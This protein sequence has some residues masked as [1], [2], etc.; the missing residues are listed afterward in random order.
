MNKEQSKTNLNGITVMSQ[1][2]GTRRTHWAVCALAATAAFAAAPSGQAAMGRTAGAFNVSPTGAATYSIPI[3][4]PKGPNGVQPNLSIAYDSNS[5]DGTMGPGW[6]LSGLGAISRCNKTWAQDGAPSAVALATSDGYCLNGNRLRMTSGTYGQAGSTYQTE[7]ADFSNITAY[8][9]AGNG[10]SHFFVQE[11]NGWTYEYGNSNDGGSTYPARITASGSSTPYQWLV[12]KVR[13]KAG[14]NYVVSYGAGQSG[15]VGIGVPLSLSYTPSAAGSSSYEYTLTFGYTTEGAAGTENGYIGGGNVVNTNRLTSITLAHGAATVRKYN[16]AYGQS[17]TTGRYRL[18]SLTECSDAASTNCLLPTAITYQNGSAGVATSPVTAVSSSCVIDLK[19]RDINNDGFNDLTC[20]SYDEESSTSYFIVSFGSASGFS[21]FVNAGVNAYMQVDFDHFLGDGIQDFL[22]E[23]DGVFYRYRWNGSSF[24]A[25]NTGVPVAPAGLGSPSP[26]VST[27]MNGDGL[28]DLVWR[29]FTGTLYARINTSSG[30]ALSFTDPIQVYTN[31]TVPYTPN[32]GIF[33]RSVGSG[34]KRLDFNGDGRGDIHLRAGDGSAVYT[35]V[36]V[37]NGNSYS[38]Q[39]TLNSNVEITASDMNDDGCTD[40]YSYHRFAE[41]EPALHFSKCNGTQEAVVTATNLTGSAFFPIDWN[42]DGTQDLMVA[43]FT[44]WQVYLVNGDGSWQSPISTGISPGLG[45][46][47]WAIV[48]MNGDGQ[49]DLASI[50]PYSF[51]G[52]IYSHLHNGAS[53]LPDRVTSIVDGYGVAFSPAYASITQG[54]YTQGSGA[55][56]PE[57]DTKA[58]RYVVSQVTTSDGIGGTYNK[59]YTYSGGRQH[60]QGRG[61][62]GFQQQTVTDSRSGAPVT[63]SYFKTT[64]PHTGMLY[65]Q[66]VFQSNG[67]TLISRTVN[68]TGLATLDATANNQRYFPNIASAATDTYEVG[69]TKNAALV[70]QR[71]TSLTYDSYGNVTSAT[72]TLTDKDSTSP[73]SPT[74]NQAWTTT[75]TNSFTPDAGSNWCVGIPTQTTVAR[76]TTGSSITRTTSITPN[77]STCRITQK[78]VEPSSGTYAVTIGYGYDA[79]GNVSSETVTGVGMSARQTLM[80]WGTTGQFPVSVTNALSQTSTAGYN[81]DLGVQMTATDANG[82]ATSFMHD[83]FAR[84]TRETRPD[85]TYTDFTYTDCTSSGCQNGDPSGSPAINKMLVAATTKDSAATTIRDDYTHLDQFD[86]VIV[87][88]SRLLGS[89]YSRVGTQYDALGNVY[90]QTAPC[91]AASCSVYWTTNTYDA[92]NRLTNQSRPISASVGTLQS[93]SYSYQGMTTLVT[94][95]PTGSPASSKTTTKVVDPNGWLRQSRDHNNYYQNFN[96]DAFGS[97]KTVTDSLSNALFSANYVY[98]IGAFQTSRTDMDLGTWSFT[99]NA[100]GEVGAYTDAKGNNFTQTFDAL[101]RVTT[102]FVTGEGTTTW[103]WGNNAANYNIGQLASLSNT[104]G[105]IEEYS[106]D[107]KSRLSQRKITS[108]AIYYFNYTYGS[109]GQID[110]LTYPTSTSSY[111]LSVKHLYENGLLKQVKDDNASTV[112]WQAGTV[113]PRGQVSQETLGNGVVTNRVYD[114]VTGWISSIQS[115]SGGGS[116]LQNESYLQDMVG[117]IIQRQQNNLGLTESFYYDSLYRLQE[118]RLGSTTNLTLTYDALGNITSRSDVAGGATWTYHATKKHAVTQAGSASYTYTYDANGNAETRNGH[119]ITWNRYNYPTVINGPGKTLTFGYDGNHQRYQQI[120]NNGSLTETTMYVG[121]LLEKVAIGTTIDWRHYIRVGRQTV[122]V[123][124]RQSTGTNTTRYVLEDHQGSVA[125]LLDNTGT[126]YVAES[127]TAFGARRDPADWSGDCPCPDL[128]KI[129]GVSRM[130]YT[131]HEAIGGVSMGLNH[132]N[133]RVQDAITGRFLSADPYI[134]EPGNTQNYNR[135]SYVY[136]NPLTYTDPSGFCRDTDDFLNARGNPIECI[137][138][139]ASWIYD[140]FINV[141]QF[142]DMSGLYNSEGGDGQIV[143]TPMDADGDSAGGAEGG[144]GQ[145]HREQS[146]QCVRDNMKYVNLAAGVAQGA[147]TGYVATGNPIG[148]L[149]GGVLGGGAGYL[150]SGIDT[151]PVNQAAGRAEIGGAAA[152]LRV[153][154]TRALSAP[155]GS[156]LGAFTGGFVGG[157]ATSALGPELGATV[158]GIVGGAN[159]SAILGGNVAAGAYRGGVAGLAGALAG[160]FIR[161]F[162]A[163]ILNDICRQ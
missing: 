109:H 47:S 94:D 51:T 73:A 2:K 46:F 21:A 64:F 11:K 39:A 6:F 41:A 33:T 77:Y 108:D 151:D 76:S 29:N 71:A 18:T 150:I 57:L 79:F 60:L 159:T 111:R 110:T 96:Y 145:T 5:G 9:S 7:L 55:T 148:A 62:L 92:L 43:G 114:A 124:S 17:P 138:V 160:T 115:G 74:Y 135:Y 44:D 25:T 13:D 90:R 22:R 136:N 158:G 40:Y 162:G 97:L 37:S 4:M 152:S 63:K 95:P 78:V 104:G 48:D 14:N 122:A 31:S 34:S 69:G 19:G 130:G 89:G 15:S 132:M 100:L 149:A 1:A 163:A 86:R 153:V 120:Y 117:N 12:N 54:S 129:A 154:G 56:F 134:T 10:P 103:T 98:G 23:S 112:F 50:D 125:N 38:A 119:A 42:S 65:Q 30:G 93:T 67:S 66:D 70:T 113:N 123:M 61:F 88:R 49:D 102:R 105:T 144:H 53:T 137:E 141:F 156:V 3:W 35:I 91:N 142:E 121:G 16:L 83:S 101:S 26:Y 140:S 36:L 52:T 24:T 27:D 155:G 80:G 87:T 118:S 59:T 68:T 28:A 147:V 161:N 146:Q 75:V 84:L 128:A 81:Y 127:F 8:G 139:V 133:G 72:E 45:A 85:G 126:S 106:Y 143:D 32:P 157:A 116:A 131:G 107:N 82:L 20:I 58:P 99:P